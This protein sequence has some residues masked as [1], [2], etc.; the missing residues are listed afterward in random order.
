M[1]LRNHSAAIL[2]PI[3]RLPASPDAIYLLRRRIH[4]VYT[5]GR[6]HGK[7][8]TQP[9]RPLPVQGPGAGA[10]STFLTNNKGCLRLDELLQ[11]LSFHN[12]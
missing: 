6:A 12:P 11:A 1:R 3:D 8:F 7:L 10:I 2:Q 9:R 4:V 5:S